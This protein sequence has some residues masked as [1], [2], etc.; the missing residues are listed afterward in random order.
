MEEEAA[1]VYR[2]YLANLKPGE[3]AK[4]IVGFVAGAATER[5]LMYGHA[6]A[7]WWTE[8]ETAIAKRQVWR[9]AGFVMAETLG[10]LGPL[11][12]ETADKLG[13]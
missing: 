2:R 1:D 3:V 11:I 13:L 12:K 5:G 6:G 7:V 9:D 4:P 10:D 8:N